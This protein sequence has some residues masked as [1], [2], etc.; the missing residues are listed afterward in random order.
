VFDPN[1]QRYLVVGPDAKPAGT[2]ALGDATG[3]RAVGRRVK[4]VDVQ[5][6]L[7]YQGSSVPALNGNDGLP[8]EALDSVPIVRWDRKS[9]RHDTLGMIKGPEMQLGGSSRGD[10]R[11]VMFRQQPLTASDDWAV[12]PDGRVAVARSGTYGLDWI[13]NGKRTAGGAVA[14]TPIRVTKADKE[15]WEQLAR[16]GRPMM[17]AVGGG[18]RLPPPPVPDAD[19]MEWPEVKPAFTGSAAMVT[20]EGEAWVRRTVPAGEQR[21]HY[22][23]FDAQGKL[24]AK[25]VL[26]AGTRLVGFGKGALYLVRTDEDGLEWLGRYRR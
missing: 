4:G 21:P 12:A 16:S 2:F 20:P 17:R 11:V 22:D 9:G 19:E 1:N 6:R 25:A 5:G 23:V 24:V 3:L 15:E 14:Y 7:Y 10:R 13:A 8:R 18:G 26:P